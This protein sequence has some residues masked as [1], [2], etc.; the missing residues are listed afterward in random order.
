MEDNKT[1]KTTQKKQPEKKFSVQEFANIK[2]L[3]S[4]E[5]FVLNY[6]YKKDK[7]TKKQ[8]EDVM[9]KEKLRKSK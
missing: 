9:V 2:G 6:R 4:R 8:W 1:T 3:N 7:K 5:K